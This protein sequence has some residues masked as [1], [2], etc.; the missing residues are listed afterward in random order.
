VHVGAKSSQNS[1]QEEYIRVQELVQKRIITPPV[2][3]RGR[4]T[5]EGAGGKDTD[6]DTTIEA[7][8]KGVSASAFSNTFMVDQDGTI[9]NV[10]SL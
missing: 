9:N 5:A 1:Q 8:D 4:T 10:T 6:S 7:A 3:R 2:L